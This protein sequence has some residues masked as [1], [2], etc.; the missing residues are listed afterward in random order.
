MKI[1]LELIENYLGQPVER[2]K[3]FYSPTKM[4]E[5]ARTNA[6]WYLARREGARIIAYSRNQDIEYEDGIFHVSWQR[7]KW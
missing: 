1:T 5:I 3:I 6:N 2:I 7:R 4:K